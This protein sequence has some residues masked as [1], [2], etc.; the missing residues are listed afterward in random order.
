M[1]DVDKVSVFA[2]EGVFDR[3]VGAVAV[4]V[5]GHVERLKVLEEL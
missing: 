2:R 4:T 3:H 1:A 5:L